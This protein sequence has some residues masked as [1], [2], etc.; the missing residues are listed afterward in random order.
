MNRL[1]KKGRLAQVINIKSGKV[2]T[3][4][5]I[6]LDKAKQQLS[7][8]ESTARMEEHNNKLLKFMKKQF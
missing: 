4:D 2:I 6:P 3:R 1:I 8:L 7:I 5:F